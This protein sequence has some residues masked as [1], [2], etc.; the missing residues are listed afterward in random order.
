MRSVSLIALARGD[1]GAAVLT[2][3]KFTLKVQ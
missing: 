1:D 3:H 2:E